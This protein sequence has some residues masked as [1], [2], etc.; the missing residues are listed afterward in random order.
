MY[1][2]LMVDDECMIAD[3]LY[4]YM[5]A[6]LEGELELYKSYSGRNAIE[7]MEETPMDI[8]VT[9]ITMPGV[10]GLMLHKRAME[11]NPRCKVIFITGYNDFSSIQY[12]LR[13]ESVDFILKSESNEVIINSI[14]KAM[15]KL[16]ED[17]SIEQT[18]VLARQ[19][20]E[21]SMPILQERLVLSILDGE[22]FSVGPFR[23][24]QFPIYV[25]DKLLLMMG[26]IDE[27]YSATKT[28][29]YKL[30]GMVDEFIRQGNR[31]F[32]VIHDDDI[33]WM[34][35][36]YDPHGSNEALTKNAIKSAMG[37]I[38]DMCLKSFN[39]SI[40]LVLS[41]D[42]IH[43]ADI[44]VTWMG[45]TQTL[46]NLTGLSTGMLL[47]EYD[48]HKPPGVKADWL[49]IRN[50]LQ[51]IN[52]SIERLQREKYE[53]YYAEL[54]G[55]LRG[56]P[57]FSQPENIEIAMRIYLAFLTHSNNNGINLDIEFEDY[58][59][60]EN[61]WDLYDVM[62]AKIAEDFFTKQHQTS[63]EHTNQILGNLRNYIHNNL[64]G[65]TSLNKL[66]EIAHFSP[67]YLSRLFKQLTNVSLTEYIGGLK[68]EKAAQMLVE[69][70]MKIVQIAT[71]L[72]FETQSYFSRFFKKYA[73]VGPQEY[74][75]MKGR[76]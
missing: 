45:L 4:E 23:E 51:Q 25:D 10:N 41:E 42:F 36:P 15:A 59:N 21:L 44:S 32:S 57:A 48:N 20:W 1:K 14:R 37:S 2:L 53:K 68:Y 27:G 63:F 47:I 38:Y 66:A 64:S 58:F 56:T 29:L 46:A 62:F 6:R 8:L 70:N 26:R 71:E 72:G 74:R 22:A 9:D 76:N 43:F 67:T 52:L 60:N 61:S 11:I 18:R 5:E 24:V 35:Q 17:I 33:L 3:L 31:V 16:D 65:D 7:I 49:H 34:I 13:N 19:Q 40:S 30:K 39:M 28:T 50:I 12:A 55:I 75:D 54:M 73:G 69:T